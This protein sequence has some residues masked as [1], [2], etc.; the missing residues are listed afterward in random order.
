MNGFGLEYRRGQRKKK[1]KPE[2]G[3]FVLA[4]IEDGLLDV[5][6]RVELGGFFLGFWG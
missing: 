3:G 5:V 1:K 2:L 6:C 4:V